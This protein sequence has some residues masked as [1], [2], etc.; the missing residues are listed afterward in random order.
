MHILV[1]HGR[2][3]N[4]GDAAMVYGTLYTLTQK[5]P[6]HTF[7]LS[8]D[9]LAESGVL[10][11][12][13]VKEIPT[14]HMVPQWKDPFLH[15]QP[16]KGK[17]SS[18][19]GLLWPM[20]RFSWTWPMVNIARKIQRNLYTHYWP[21]MNDLSGLSIQSDGQRIPL[22]DW[23]DQF[24]AGIIP[25]GLITDE[26]TASLYRQCLLMHAFHYLQK[27]FYVY[28]VQFGPF[29]KSLLQRRASDAVRTTVKCTIRSQNFPKDTNAIFMHDMSMGIHPDP[30]TH[31][32]L[33][34][35][36]LMPGRFL[37]YHMRSS[38]YNSSI[39]QYIPYF[40]S[41]L[42]KLSRTLNMPLVHV[43]ISL[44]ESDN[45]RRWGK[46][47]AKRLSG[48]D[49]YEIEDVTLKDTTLIKGIV[50]QSHGMI[51]VSYHAC[52]F[53][54]TQGVPAVN[55]HASKHYSHKA[56]GLVD[57]FHDERISL[58]IPE[59]CLE[60]AHTQCLSMFSN[61]SFPRLSYS[62]WNDM[63]LL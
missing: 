18:G 36:N 28:G 29:T 37:T 24:D 20:T 19:A 61:A 4:F 32:W 42:Q 50:G 6:A 41:L 46:Y 40:A 51:G 63:L 23:C 10:S 2:S 30:H 43:P 54:L 52:L 9:G 35:H 16:T 57:T 14:Y 3:E 31:Q 62:E 21:D 53:A 22:L 48:V 33:T 1:D 49:H 38:F 47:I 27:P 59:C 8:N 44:K 13:S 7:A 55:I 56:K 15:A 34:R 45:D 11:L 12:P 39:K 5:Y 26:F 58:C 17:K 60:E 25:G